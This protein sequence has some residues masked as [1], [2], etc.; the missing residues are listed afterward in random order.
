MTGR[1]MAWRF[2]ATEYTKEENQKEDGRLWVST[3]FLHI[4]PQDFNKINTFMKS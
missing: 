2:K 4:G 1:V 3:W